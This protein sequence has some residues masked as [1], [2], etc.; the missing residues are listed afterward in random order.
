MALAEDLEVQAASAA[1]E[2]AVLAGQEALA[3]VADPVLRPGSLRAAEGLADLLL[4]SLAA[5]AE[6]RAVALVAAE[7]AEGAE[8]AG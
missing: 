3:A 2:E 5:A 1:R 7:A 8:E 6:P 4:D